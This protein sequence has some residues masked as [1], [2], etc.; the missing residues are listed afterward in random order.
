MLKTISNLGGAYQTILIFTMHMS[1]LVCKWKIQEDEMKT[2]MH[3]EYRWHF[4]LMTNKAYIRQAVISKLIMFTPHTWMK[5]TM[6]FP[7][8]GGKSYGSNIKEWFLHNW[9]ATNV[10]NQQTSNEMHSIIKGNINLSAFV[11]NYAIFKIFIRSPCTKFH[12]F[13]TFRY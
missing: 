6:I 9:N 5:V 7:E 10:Q 1:S 12:S 13:S 4:L 3:K 11:I 2:V 8:D